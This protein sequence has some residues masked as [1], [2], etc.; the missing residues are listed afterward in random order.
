MRIC[1]PCL[2]LADEK[3][4]VAM[5]HIHFRPITGLAADIAAATMARCQ[6]CQQAGEIFSLLASAASGE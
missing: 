2:S 5:M 4:A 1:S 3:V 6:T